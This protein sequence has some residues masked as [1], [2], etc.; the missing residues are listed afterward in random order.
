MKYRS[1]LIRVQAGLYWEDKTSFS[2]YQSLSSPSTMMWQP[3][4]QSSEGCKTLFQEGFANANTRKRLLYGHC[5]IP[6]HGVQC[7]LV[8]VDNFLANFSNYYFLLLCW[9]M[10]PSA[11]C[12]D[13]ILPSLAATSIWKSFLKYEWCPWNCN[14]QFHG[15]HS[16]FRKDLQMLVAVRHR[17]C[18][19][20][21]L[22]TRSH[23]S[24]T[25][26]K[27]IIWKIR[28]NC[29]L[30]LSYVTPVLPF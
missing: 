23:I 30:K 5:Y 10:W 12:G 9:Y 4:P 7:R 21:P 13:Y 27:I 17:P 8:L 29:P 24:A 28:K 15:H 3:N 20:S 22:C 2:I 25:K 1:S 26:Q 14:L 19:A 6:S 18:I 16:Y 11:R